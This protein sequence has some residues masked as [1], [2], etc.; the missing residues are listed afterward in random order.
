M[1]D[2]AGREHLLLN[3][4]VRADP[5]KSHD[6]GYLERIANAVKRVGEETWTWE[7]VREWAKEKARSTKDTARRLFLYLSGEAYS[8]PPGPFYPPGQGPDSSSPTTGPTSRRDTQIG[9]NTE[10]GGFWST[11]T[12]LFSGIGKGLSASSQ[13]G[14][15]GA[16]KLV[17]VFDEGE[18]HC[19]LIKVSKID[20]LVPSYL[21]GQVSWLTSFCFP[22]LSVERRW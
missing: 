21:S 1:Q 19:D 14:S 8:G 4:Y 9:R 20:C 10:E 5:K 16:E 12:G 3:F 22:P 7:E 2:S 11:I 18:V 17:E 15:S 6:E 13:S